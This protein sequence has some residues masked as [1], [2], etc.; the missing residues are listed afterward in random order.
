MKKCDLHTHSSFSDGSKT[1]AEIIAEAKALGLTVALTDH[2]TIGGLSEFL[3]EAE[4]QGVTALPG[5]EI[6][7]DFEG[8]ELH[9]LGL[10]IQEKYYGN[11]EFFL[12]ELM[13]LKEISNMEMVERLNGAGYNI[14]YVD[15]KKRTQSE[16]V[17][18]AH[19]AAELFEKGYVTSIKEAFATILDE[20]AGFYVPAP[21][22]QLLDTIAFLREIRA[23]P[24]LAH[25]LQELD[26]AE[27]R[28][29]LPKAMEAGLLGIEIFH[30]S[31][32][33]EQL[34]AAAAIAEDFGI[35]KSGGSDYHGSN[36]PDIFLGTGKGNLAIPERV[37]L[38]LCALRDRLCAETN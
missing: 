21:R 20:G 34:E 15:V 18:R 19:V 36:K 2:N 28:A 23:V 38:D 25:P 8:T 35:A 4:K 14:D 31:Y 12:K 16:N 9:L 5:I 37:Y 13:L 7:T 10:F 11:I 27:L 30:S 33:D 26:D 1:P 32:S 6:T 22:A 29:L 17:N 24:V 3:S